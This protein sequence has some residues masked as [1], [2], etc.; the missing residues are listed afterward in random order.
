MLLSRKI[1]IYPNNKQKTLLFKSAQVSNYAYNYAID[2]VK[3][4][5]KNNETWSDCII[6]KNLT[7]EKKDNSMSFLN[8]VSCDVPK[9]AIKDACKAYKKFFNKTADYPKYKNYKSKKS[10][11]ID[12]YKIKFNDHKLRLPKIP[13]TVKSSEKILVENGKEMKNIRVSFDGIDWWL[14]YSFEVNYKEDKR[15]SDNSLGIDVGIKTYATLS[16]K[17]VFKSNKNKIK[18]LYKRLKRTQR[19]LNKYY[20]EKRKINKK[21]GKSLKPNNIIKKE[22]KLKST[23]IKISNIMN[24]F[25]H[26]IANEIVNKDIN[27]IIVEDLNIK[28]MIKNHKL[29]KSIIINSFNKF[30]FTLEYKCKMRNIEFIKANRFYPST[31]TCS[32][33]GHV[34]QGENKLTLK[35]RVYHCKE[36][37]FEEDRDINAAINLS[38][39]SI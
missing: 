38:K 7:K 9:Q 28:G 33:C 15:R 37:G 11:Y 6:R 4:Y 24:D 3:E 14:S 32:N 18:I 31:Q 22:I 19:K 16:D 35:D 8:E 12:S 39:Y 5:Y 2:K 30:F 27:R 29:S 17:S 1:K 34:L 23:Y 36:C 26:K 13:G 10:F 25:I 20:L 21:G